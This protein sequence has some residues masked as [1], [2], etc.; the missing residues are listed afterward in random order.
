MDRRII[1][2]R[3]ALATG[4]SQKDVT[5]VIEGALAALK[6]EIAQGEKTSVTN[7]GTFRRTSMKNMAYFDP[8]TGEKKISCAN[9]RLSFTLAPSFK[10]QLL[11]ETR[12][13]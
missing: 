9:V 10:K 1:I 11:D 4:V 13:D 7:F 8:R 3:L 12:H 2:K 5:A 6:Q